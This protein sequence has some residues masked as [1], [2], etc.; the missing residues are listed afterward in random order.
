VFAILSAAIV[1]PSVM[2]LCSRLAPGDNAD[3]LA[4]D[5]LEVALAGLR[6][7][8]PLTFTAACSGDSSDPVR[9]S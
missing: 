9:P 8:T 2:H 6:S 4:N 3:A 1:G 5:T 7:G